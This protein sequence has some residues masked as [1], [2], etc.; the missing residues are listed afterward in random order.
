MDNTEKQALE[1]WQEWFEKDGDPSYGERDG[2]PVCF[3]CGWWIFENENHPEDC[4]YIRAK[5]LI[6]GLERKETK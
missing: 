1:L 2:D 3:F 4:V 6:E 5:K